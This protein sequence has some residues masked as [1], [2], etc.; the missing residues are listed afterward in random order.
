MARVWSASRSRL[1]QECARKYWYRYHLA[2]AGRRPGAGAEARTA[3]RVQ[4]LMGVEMWLGTLVHE[5]LEHTLDAWRHG[6]SYTEGEALEWALWRLRSQYRGSALYWREPEGMHER[7]PPLLSLHYFA[8]EAPLTRQQG[9]EVRDRVEQ[10]LRNFFRSDLAGELQALERERWLPI[11]RHAAVTLEAGDSREALTLF[12]KPDC[13]FRAGDLLHILDWKTGRPAAHWERL[14]PLQMEPPPAANPAPGGVPLPRVAGSGGG[15]G[16]RRTG[17]GGG[18][19][20]RRRGAHC[21]CG[22]ARRAWAGGR[23][24]PR[25]LSCYRTAASVPLVP[26]SGALPG[27]ARRCGSREPGRRRAGRGGMGRGGVS[28]WGATKLP[29]QAGKGL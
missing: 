21:R 17:R 28:S 7:P 18:R 11:E 22:G 4:S 8:D 12:V 24:C 3:H 20:L 10:C 9:S 29:Q 1:F 19:D 27:P 6:R 5:A 15:I 23:A 13:A 26:V 2:K 25:G 16:P 14:C